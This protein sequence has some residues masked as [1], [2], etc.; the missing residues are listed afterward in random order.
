MSKTL[1]G[2]L[3]GVAEITPSSCRGLGS[4]IITAGE[5]VGAEGVMRLSFAIFIPQQ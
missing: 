2:L 5:D 4:I 1:N 3:D